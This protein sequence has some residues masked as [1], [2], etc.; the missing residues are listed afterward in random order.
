M[1]NF[2]AF[3]KCYTLRIFN[4]YF[5]KPVDNPHNKKILLNNVSGCFNN[6]KKLLETIWKINLITKL[7]NISNGWGKLFSWN[8]LYDAF[9]KR[10]KENADI[11]ACF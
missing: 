5:L 1:H 6:S 3:Q 11:G 2:L 7:T 9:L 4:T 10:E 8:N